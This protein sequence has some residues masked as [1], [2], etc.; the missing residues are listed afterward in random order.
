M[1]PNVNLLPPLPSEKNIFSDWY[2]NVCLKEH[3]MVFKLCF[4]LKLSFHNDVIGYFSKL[5]GA[6]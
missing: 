2:E 5:G 1:R 4:F 6:W 3:L